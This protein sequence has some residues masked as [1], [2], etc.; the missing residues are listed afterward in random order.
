[1]NDNLIDIPVPGAPTPTPKQTNPAPTMTP[2]NQETMLTTAAERPQ[3]STSLSYVAEQR[4]IYALAQALCQ[5]D[6]LPAAYKGKAAD[7]A[8]AIDMAAR[9]GVPPL[10]VMQ[11]LYVVKGKPSWSG[12]ACLSV[13][14]KK[15]SKVKV[16]YTG[17][18]G[19]DSR[20]CYI[21]A[22]DE[23]GDKLEGTEV[24]IAMAKAEGWMT[25]PKWKNMPEQM[26]AYR[27]GAFFAR[28]HCPDVLMG[29]AVEGEVEDSDKSSPRRTVEDVL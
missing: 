21:T 4:K 13:I 7:T 2:T 1:M 20:G 10:M 17:Q 28:V 9:M 26:L 16:I 19:T 24:T 18:K 22:I 25:N 27:A 12:Q 11:N 6:I 3:E 15:Y 29:C 5:A 14:K 8:I 23:D